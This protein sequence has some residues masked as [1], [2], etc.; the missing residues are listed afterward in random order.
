MAQQRRL[1]QEAHAAH[2]RQQ[3]AARVAA[4]AAA[5]AAGEG[6]VLVVEDEADAGGGA[7]GGGASAAASSAAPPALPP[8]R[9]THHDVC[10]ALARNVEAWLAA[11]GAGES[12]A[13]SE[14]AQAQLC[15][16]A[17]CAGE[18]GEQA[19]L[20]LRALARALPARGAW[21]ECLTRVA[22]A[23]ERAFCAWHGAALVWRV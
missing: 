3:R 5:S 6:E 9:P 23:G 22:A 17:A 2:Q 11:Q 21:R 13:P 7:G 15:Q 12:S 4:A 14:A 16:A 1:L 8:P 18:D 10:L 20:L 19:R